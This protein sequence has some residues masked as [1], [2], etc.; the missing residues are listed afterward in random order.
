MAKVKPDHNWTPK[1][2]IMDLWPNVSGNAVNALDQSETSQPTPVFWR[3]DGSIAHAPVM[4]YFLDKVDENERTF[5][6]R[7]YKAEIE[8]IPTIDQDDTKTEKSTADWIIAV[9]QAALASGA[10]Q[11][12]ICRY[13]PAWTYDDRPQPNGEWAVV[14]AFAH[15]YD[16]LATAP[17]NDSLIEVM[18]Q[19]GSAGKA[20]K[21]LTNW[22]HENG[23][24]AEAK[25]GPNSEDVLMIPAAIAAGLGELGKHGSMINRQFGSNFRLSMVTTDLPLAPD[26]A[27]VFG[28]EAFCLNCQICTNACPPQ[29][30]K[31]EKQL[32]RGTT[33]W[34]VDF[35]K[36]VPYFVD[37]QACGICIA[38]CPWSR[39]GIADNLVK[40]MIKRLAA[41][42]TRVQES[43]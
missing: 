32:V 27:D 30:I 33:K 2:E 10:D 37:N 15:D 36:C 43:N 16:A 29:A 7:G 28:G 23:Y 12:G 4:Y 8:A 1:Q 38:V 9:K 41:Q 18:N 34:Y 13:D 11:V 21:H 39:P 20:A 40:K 5:T 14:M 24:I 17:D 19:Y 35:D 22:I 31:S 25:T 26:M 3:H 6:A 42:D